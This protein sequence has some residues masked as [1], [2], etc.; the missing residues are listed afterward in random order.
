MHESNKQ[1][2]RRAARMLPALVS[3]SVLSAGLFAQ[4]EEPEELDAF[5]SEE[6]PIEENILPTSRPF[7]SVYGTDRS[8]LDT[9]RN[10]TIISREQLDSIAI[11]D[12]RDFSKLT[13]SS[14][15]KTNFGSPSTPNLRGQEADLFV[16][17]M[18]RGGSVNGNGLPV[19]FNAV[20]SVNIVKGPAGVVYGTTNYL[21]GYADLITKKPY[22]DAERGSFGVSVGSYD[23]YTWNVDYSKPVSDKLAYRVSYEGKEWDGYW[24]LWKQNSQ[25]LYFALTYRPNEKYTLE[26]NIEYFQADYTENWGIN[27]VSQDLVDNG[28]YLPNAQTD[29]EYLDYIAM[30]G[31]GAGF[32][33]GTPGVDYASQFGGAGFATIALPDLDNPVPV[34]RTWKL[35]A[36]GDDSFGRMVSGGVDQTLKLENFDLVNKTFFSWKDRQTF[37]SYHYSELLRDNIAFENRTEIR[38]N[39]E[40]GDESSF[41]INA[42]VRLR[43]D[44]IWSANHFYNEPVNFWDMTR[45]PDTRRVPDQGFLGSAAWVFDEEPRGVLDHWYIGIDAFADVPYVTGGDG[46]NFIFGPFAQFDLKLNDTF[47]VLAGFTTDFVDAEEVHPVLGESGSF[48]F[49]GDGTIADDMAERGYLLDESTELDNYN[50]SFIYKPSEIST[51][52]ATYNFSETYSVDTGGRILPSSFGDTQESDLLEFGTKFVFADGKFFLNAALVDREFTERNIDGSVDQVF[53]DAYEIEFNYQPNRN[54]FATLGFSYMDAERTAGFFASP[55]TI[56][57]ADET[58][59]IYISPLFLAPSELV[60]APGIPE[61]LVNS[62]IRYKWDNGFGMTLGFIGWGDTYSGYSDFE[63]AVPDLTGANGGEDYILTANTAVLGFQ[64][65]ADLSFTYEYENWAYKLTIFNVTDEENWD[66]NNS[67]YGNGS[68]LPRQ[69]ARFELSAKYS[70]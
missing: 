57:R 1:Q 25:A 67:G 26:A 15:T 51:L 10:V 44:D 16:N 8:I 48:D 49:S 36:P 41:D 29:Q 70:F 63:I 53:I 18:R 6:V 4:D 54:L 14:Y 2:I 40:F 60:P 23:Q 27:R 35:A 28:L 33:A 3:A 37:S 20:E 64:Y 22:F 32:W 34:D 69:P 21:G 9:P 7:N 68:I 65:E 56:D 66:V 17:G 12:V 11:K 42:G 50:L 39:N 30:L 61:K 13:S 31:N 55:Y 45:D 38:F 62:L 52:Y 43:Y 47:S 59:G 19:N 24:E 58:G 5:I 46:K